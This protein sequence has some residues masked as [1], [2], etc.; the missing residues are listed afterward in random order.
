VDR[1]LLDQLAL[2]SRCDVLVSPHSGFAMAGL[3][4]GTPWLAISGNRWP[5]Y[6]F[7][8]VPF[9]SVVPDLD[10]FPAFETLAPESVPVEDDGPRSPSMCQRRIEQDLDEIVEGAARLVEHRWSFEEAMAHYVGA[11][12]TLGTRNGTDLW[13]VDG[14]HRKY[15]P[16]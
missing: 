16:G 12:K 1:P 6:Y 7:N 5:E 4:V 3:A 13:S 8:G 15:L 10:R 14:V 9:Y 2:V 11:M